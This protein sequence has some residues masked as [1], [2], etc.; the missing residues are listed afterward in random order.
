MER[1]EYGASRFALSPRFG[2]RNSK[3]ARSG[4][5]LIEAICRA[6]FNCFAARAGTY[7]G[8]RYY[9][10]VENPR[11]RLLPVPF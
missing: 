5:S 4:Q 1:F 7:R 10:A 11:G 8:I 6:G 2:M 3:L 9:K